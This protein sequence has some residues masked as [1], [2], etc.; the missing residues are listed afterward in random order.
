[1]RKV[2]PI[3]MSE[4]MYDVVLERK[5]AG[6]HSS[7]SEYIRSLVR[8]DA[9]ES[10]KPVSEPLYARPRRANEYMVDPTDQDAYN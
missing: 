3:S 2:V 4:A 1:M 6:F 10:R 5:H 9:R 8:R 7:V